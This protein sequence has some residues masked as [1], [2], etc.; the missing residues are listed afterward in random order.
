MRLTPIYHI[1]IHTHTPSQR[2]MRPNTYKYLY[3]HTAAKQDRYASCLLLLPSRLEP[4][5]GKQTSPTAPNPRLEPQ[6]P[7]P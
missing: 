4:N 7:V 2:D 1:H 5:P 3:L 6:F